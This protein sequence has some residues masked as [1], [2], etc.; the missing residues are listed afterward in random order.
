MAPVANRVKPFYRPRV[1]IDSDSARPVLD[2]HARRT[3]GIV[4]EHLII[5][6]TAETHHDRCGSSSTAVEATSDRIYVV[7]LQHHMLERRDP[8]HFNKRKRVVSGVAVKKSGG[9][10]PHR[11]VVADSKS[12]Q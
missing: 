1:I 4:R 2:R 8:R 12:K 10:R 5:G 11:N 3:R 7:H 9:H 6:V